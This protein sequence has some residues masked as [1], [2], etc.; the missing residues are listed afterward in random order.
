MIDAMFYAESQQEV[1]GEIRPFL[2]SKK[3]QI[4]FQTVSIIFVFRE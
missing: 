2:S 3:S 1:I 4:D